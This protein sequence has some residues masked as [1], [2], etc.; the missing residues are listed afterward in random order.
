MS[1]IFTLGHYR[2][3]KIADDLYYQKRLD[4]Y[5]RIISKSLS[6]KNKLRIEFKGG[7]F[8]LYYTY[9]TGE[10]IFV[11]ECDDKGMK[12]FLNGFLHGHFFNWNEPQNNS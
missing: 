10:E 12:K 9:T 6:C 3:E 7:N 2:R 1:S 4:N 5:R 11:Y 8:A